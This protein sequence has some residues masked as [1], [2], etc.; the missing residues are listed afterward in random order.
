MKQIGVWAILGIWAFLS[1]AGIVFALWQG[2]SGRAFAATSATASL[3][4]FSMMLFAGR[5]IADKF[6]SSLGSGSGL[7]LAVVVFFLYMVYLFG[8]GTFALGRLGIMAAF[9]FVPLALAMSAKGAAPGS[10]QDFLTIASVWA[11]VKFGP[12]HYLWP[13]PGR[14]LAYILTVLV[15]VNVAIAIFLLARRNE[16][17]WLQH[18]LGKELVDLCS[19]EVFSPLVVVAIPLGISTALH[20]LRSAMAPRGVRS[21]GLSAGYSGVHGLAR[22]I[23]VSRVTAESFGALSKSELAGWWTSSVLFGLS[24]ITNGLSELAVRCPRYH[25]RPLL[26]LDLAQNRFSSSPRHWFMPPST[27]PGTSCSAPSEPELTPIGRTKNLGSFSVREPL[28]SVGEP[29]A[30]RQQRNRRSYRPP[31]RQHQVRHQP[32]P[33]KCHPEYLPLHPFSLIADFHH[34]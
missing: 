16:G 9:V 10:W 6:T 28:T 22:G 2:Y 23:F 32:Q 26:R 29:P 11:F 5:G 12:V 19:S 7:L 27:L 14:R 33:A 8:T 13:Y 21:S 34:L 24:H 31:E 18:R 30:K 15:A 20:R 4:L 3:L 25:R 17:R 1:F